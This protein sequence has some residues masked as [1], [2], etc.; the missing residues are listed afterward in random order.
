[1]D[2]RCLLWKNCSILVLCCRYC[3]PDSSINAYATFSRRVNL[4]I[5][6]KVVSHSH[7]SSPESRCFPW[8][9]RCWFDSFHVLMLD[10]FDTL[11]S[12][13]QLHHIEVALVIWEV[14]PL[15]AP[16]DYP[17]IFIVHSEIGNIRVIVR[18]LVAFSR[19]FEL[20]LERL[21]LLLSHLVYN[22]SW[23]LLLAWQDTIQ[24]LGRFRIVEHHFPDLFV[25]QFCARLD[26]G[27]AAV[28][29]GRSLTS[30]ILQFATRWFS[31]CEVQIASAFTS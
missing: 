30:I 21:C 29:H 27:E 2:D 7:S 1:M 28:F 8:W 26:T 19:H 20:L 13:L 23:K 16:S 24:E 9:R 4:H 12:L 25:G 17:F 11:A 3:I 31:A 10:I 5:L 6:S 15:N 14:L 22:H 18:P